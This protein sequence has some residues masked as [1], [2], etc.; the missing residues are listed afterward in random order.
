M[1]AK[2]DGNVSVVVMMTVKRHAIW[3]DTKALK[4]TFHTGVKSQP[5]HERTPDQPYEGRFL[6][7]QN[8]QTSSGADPRMRG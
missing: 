2:D 3:C 4:A 5:H 8:D 7:D 6:N 1:G